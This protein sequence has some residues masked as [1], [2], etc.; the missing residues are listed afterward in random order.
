MRDNEVRTKQSEF[1]IIEL[2]S[3]VRDNNLRNSKSA[4]DVFSYEIP[5]VSFYDF[6]EGFCLYPLGEVINGHDQE[7]S[8]QR[9]LE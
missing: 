9:S 7:F 8:L 4:D 6:G 3:I 2:P 1:F 5:G